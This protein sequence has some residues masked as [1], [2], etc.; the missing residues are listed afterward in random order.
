MFNN[1]KNKLGLCTCK[2]CIRKAKYNIS[3][4]IIRYRGL[5]CSKHLE[6][7]ADCADMKKIK[8]ENI[9]ERDK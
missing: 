9:I 6:I 7:L 4:P 1:I 3:I 5:I 8:I 2:W